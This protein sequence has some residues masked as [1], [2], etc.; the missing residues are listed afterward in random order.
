METDTKGIGHTCDTSEF[1]YG[2]LRQVSKM[3]LRIATRLDEINEA[4][5]TRLKFEI[6]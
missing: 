2:G 6:S 5:F 1:R 3:R 4:F